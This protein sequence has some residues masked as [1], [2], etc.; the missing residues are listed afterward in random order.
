MV[1][2]KYT[3]IYKALLKFYP[4]ISFGYIYIFNFRCFRASPIHPSSKYL[5]HEKEQKKKKIKIV[6]FILIPLIKGCGI[7]ELK[8]KCFISLSRLV[9]VVCL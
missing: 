4:F 3:F 6:T 9:F 1:I 5:H 7:N 2:L 8:L